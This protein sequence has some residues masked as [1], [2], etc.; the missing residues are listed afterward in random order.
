MSKQLENTP[1]TGCRFFSV[2]PRPLCMTDGNMCTDFSCYREGRVSREELVSLLSEGVNVVRA[3][4]SGIC[5]GPW[6]VRS[7]DALDRE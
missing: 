1:C 6:V 3:V 5:H 7:L 4:N 2:H